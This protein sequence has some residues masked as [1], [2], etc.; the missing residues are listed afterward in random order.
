M[1]A[2]YIARR[3]WPGHATS[4]ASTN[5]PLKSTAPGAS[6]SDVAI[7]W[8]TST[9]HKWKPHVEGATWKDYNLICSYNLLEQHAK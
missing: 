4:R 7:S 8:Q 5:G 9:I 1:I 2:S 6:P 3:G